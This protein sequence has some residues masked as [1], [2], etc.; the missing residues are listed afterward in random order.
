MKK[1]SYF[2]SFRNG[3]YGWRFLPEIL[4][5]SVFIFTSVR[6]RK[7]SSASKRWSIQQPAACSKALQFSSSFINCCIHVLKKKETGKPL[8][9]MTCTANKL[10]SI[11]NKHCT[12]FLVS[13]RNKTVDD[14]YSETSVIFL[15]W[16][17]L[18]F[19][20]WG[21]RKKSCSQ[22]ESFLYELDLSIKRTRLLNMLYMSSEIPTDMA[23]N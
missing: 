13:G 5:W 11:V 19:C 23:K 20:H 15:P 22:S 6:T 8:R 3:D 21:I 17:H 14:F 4:A 18:L 2:L 1:R 12:G 16:I 7:P 9:T 10:H